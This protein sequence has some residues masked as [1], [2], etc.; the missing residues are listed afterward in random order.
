MNKFILPLSKRP[1]WLEYPHSFCRIVE[2]SLTDI[3]P[4]HIFDSLKAQ[5][6]FQRISERYPSREMFPFAYRQDN[7]DLA[8]WIRGK[9][10]KVFIIHDFASVGWEGEGEFE[11]VW[12]WF[13]SAVEESILWD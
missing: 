13:R 10:E 6:R 5:V 2:Q 12:T 7:D 8:C 4:W 9:G 1:G 3:T 11:D